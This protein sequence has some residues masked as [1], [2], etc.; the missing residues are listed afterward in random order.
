MQQNT[1]TAGCKAQLKEPCYSTQRRDASSRTSTLDSESYFYDSCPGGDMYPSGMKRI[2]RLSAGSKLSAYYYIGSEL[3]VCADCNKKSTSRPVLRDI[4]DRRTGEPKVL[5]IISKSRLPPGPD[6]LVNWRMLCEKLL[7]FEP[8][9][10]IMRVEQVW[11]SE[12]SFY[13]VTEKLVGGELFEFLLK[14]K[15]IPEDICKYIMKQIIQAVELLHNRN[16]LHRDIKPENIMFRN[17]TN[18]ALPVPERY[19]LV[20]IDFDTCKMMDNAN[21]ENIEIVNGKRRLV[22]TYGYL[23]PEILR[24]EEYSTASD[25]WSIGIVLYILMTGVPPVSMEKMYDAKSSHAVLTAAETNGIDFNMP[26]LIE[27]PLAR[28]LCRR[29]L[30]FD[31]NK[32]I[33]SATDALAH[34]WLVGLTSIFDRRLKIK[35]YSMG[36]N[37]QDRRHGPADSAPGGHIRALFGKSS[38]KGGNHETSSSSTKAEGTRKMPLLECDTAAESPR[39]KKRACMLYSVAVKSTVIQKHPSIKRSCFFF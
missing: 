10:N 21:S 28:D 36:G 11:E 39:S 4:I 1:A 9:A 13:V 15:V 22:G 25:M 16:M 27:F 32:R 12:T 37:S 31:R 35:N 38:A 29:L 17:P 24:G 6:G 23:A 20:L 34:P 14:E 19:E 33:A 7:N 30:S 3:R 5:K 26:P 18:S 2:R 8:C